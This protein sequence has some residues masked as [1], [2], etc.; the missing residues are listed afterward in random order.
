MKLKS[1]TIQIE[2]ETFEAREL[3]IRQ[4]MPLITRMQDDKDG[5]V[6]LELIGLCIHKN[7]APLGSDAGDVGAGTFMRFQ[8][9][10]LEVNGLNAN[11][12]GNG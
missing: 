12:E 3:P 5:A 10:V 6:Q 8:K 7:G 1:Q 4:I 2:D 9:A 11:A